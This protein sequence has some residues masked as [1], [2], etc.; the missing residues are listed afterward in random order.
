MD[1]R[2]RLKQALDDSGQTAKAL[3]KHTRTSYTAV[4]HYTSGR[5]DMPAS[6]VA[7]AAVFL[8]VSVEDLV[9]GDEALLVVLQPDESERAAAL[10]AAEQLP[11]MTPHEA[12][13]FRSTLARWLKADEVEFPERLEH[14][15]T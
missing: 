9:E 10:D 2:T 8:Q 13:A 1:M 3:A 11:D 5:R 15:P 4:R 12:Q 7:K 6:F 14:S